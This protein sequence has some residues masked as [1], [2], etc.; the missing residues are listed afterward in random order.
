[1]YSLVVFDIV[2]ADQ[3]DSLKKF[4]ILS[5]NVIFHEYIRTPQVATLPVKPFGSQS[6]SKFQH[7][8]FFGRR[9]TDVP[10]CSTFLSSNL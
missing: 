10:I 6:P 3:H 8:N 2:K 9:L 5:E 7:F 4:C 1:M